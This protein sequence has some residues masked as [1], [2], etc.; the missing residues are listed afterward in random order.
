[1]MRMSSLARLVERLLEEGPPRLSDR[2]IGGREVL[3]RGRTEPGGDGDA[4]VARGAA[5]FVDMRRAIAVQVMRGDLDDVEAELGDLFHVFQAVG[6]P[7][8]LP[9][10]VINA[11]FHLAPPV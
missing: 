2:R 10:R 3:L 11:E 1:M 8:L 9:V 6:A 5:D 7:L 4:V